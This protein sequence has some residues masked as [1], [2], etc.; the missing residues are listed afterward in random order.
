MLWPFVAHGLVFPL[1]PDAPVYLW[2]TRL[3]GHDGLS[4]IGHRPGAPALALVIQAALGRSVVEAVA[5]LEVALAVAVGLSSAALLRG[6]TTRAGW[7]LAGALSGTFAVHLAA[8]YLANLLNA[9]VFLAAAVALAEAT[10]RGAWIAAGALAAGGL[11]HPPFFLLGAAIL[12][13]TAATAWGRDRAEAIRIGGS[14]LGAGAIVGA[15]LLALRAGPPPSDTDTSRDAFLRRAGLS[16]ELVRSFRDRFVHRWARYVQW[17]SVPLAVVG[18]GEAEGFLGRFLRAWGIATVLGVLVGLVSGWFPPDRLVTFGF[19]VPIL[20]ALGLARLSRRLEPRRALAVS[21]VAA[22]TVAMLAGAFIAWDRQEPFL[23]EDE[24]RTATIA[25]GTVSGLDA[26][27]PL[28]FLVNEPDE[29]VSFLAARANNVIRASVPPDRIRDVL[30]VVPPADGP[31]EGAERRALERLTAADLREAEDRAGRPATTVVL[32]P[33]DPIDRPPGA[34]VVDP[35]EPSDEPV[36]VD[37]LQPSSPWRIVASSLLVLALVWAVGLG[38]ARFL[39]ADRVAA[40]ALAPALGS[41]ALV[42]SAVAL[43]RLGVAIDAAVGAWVVSGLA[44]GCGYVAWAVLERR[45]HARPAPEI[46]E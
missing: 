33:F 16:P 42:L 7:M 14:V 17:A 5:A 23:S 29:T 27:V 3:A 32:T 12:L 43:E 21:A 15:G 9:A 46:H 6:R 20:A 44:G 4:V 13:L 26:G 1:G 30:V 28:A 18:L 38:W 11:A 31:A 19:V 36:A 34:L 41:A 10:R 25:N 35:A 2:W 40:A 39:V 37:P 45:P 8:G 24:V 22:L